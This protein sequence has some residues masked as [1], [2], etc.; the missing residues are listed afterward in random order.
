[1]SVH[2]YSSLLRHASYRAVLITQFLGALNDNILRIVVGLY[3]LS[4]ALDTDDPALWVSLGGI[5]F[6]VPY[7][8]F[9]GHAGQL[10]DSIS[11][12]RVL[13]GAKIAEVA[14]MGAAWLAFETQSLT[15][16]TAI[17]FLMAT[18]SAY[19]SPARYG[20]LPELLTPA[21]LGPANGLGEML[22]FVAIIIGMGFG[23]FL[24]EIADGAPLWIALPMVLIAAVGAA[25]STFIPRNREKRIVKRAFDCSTKGTGL[26]RG[27]DLLRRRSMLAKGVVGMSA[28]WCVGSLLQID[29]L[30]LGTDTL[31]LGQTGIGLLQGTLGLGVGTGGLIAGRLIR[32]VPIA[33]LAQ[34]GAICMTAALFALVF[35][36]SNTITAFAGLF[37]AGCGG[38]AVIIPIIVVLQTR[39]D[40][41][42][43]GRLFAVNNFFNMV[44][45]LVGIGAFWVLRVGFGLTPDG[46]VHVL[47]FTS[48]VVLG[49]V[50]FAPR[51]AV[52]SIA[53]RCR[54]A[55]SVISG[56]KP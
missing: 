8:L 43:R 19:F 45:V 34:S 56:S 25:A 27:F 22:M 15:A 37:L 26:R 17:L 28:F 52:R 36:P 3:V 44:A 7:L 41:A 24:F 50:A 42:S 54:A 33:R 29:I 46:I 38:G 31:G 4:P 18:Q 5:A 35:A 30:F 40:P 55:T 1:M 23:G 13:I 16:M 14:I 32:R 51:H 9:A 39:C 11:K 6:I 2:N 48:V 47:A 12:R 20:I 49:L 10:S 53:A 21:D